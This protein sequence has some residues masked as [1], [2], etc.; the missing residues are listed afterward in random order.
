M[1]MNTNNRDPN[2]REL[3]DA[4]L[5]AY[6]LGQLHEHERAAV[7]AQLAGLDQQSAGKLR[8]AV[9]EIRA[10]A[11]HVAEASRHDPRPQPSP[12]LRAAVERRLRARTEDLEPVPKTAPLAPQ[13]GRGELGP[14]K[15]PRTR[16]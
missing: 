1:T 7:E 12:G 13:A 14:G 5:T 6:A 11:G 16:S 4:R 15:A 10:L 2:S 8:R 9:E 3:D